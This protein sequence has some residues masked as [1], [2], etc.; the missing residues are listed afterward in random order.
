VVSGSSEVIDDVYVEYQVV[1]LEVL[2]LFD[3]GVDEVHVEVHV[4]EVA[5]V[6]SEVDSVVSVLDQ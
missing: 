3:R 2:E 4:A 6:V 5:G 1:V